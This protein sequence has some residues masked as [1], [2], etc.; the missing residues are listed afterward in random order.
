MAE[1]KS[2]VA[3]HQ[4]AASSTRFAHSKSRSSQPDLGFCPTTWRVGGV[5]LVSSPLSTRARGPEIVW[6]NEIHLEHELVQHHLC[7]RLLASATMS[8][9][10]TDWP[11]QPLPAPTQTCSNKLLVCARLKAPASAVST[12]AV[13]CAVFCKGCHCHA[14]RIPS[15][16]HWQARRLCSWRSRNRLRHDTFLLAQ[17]RPSL[18]FVQAYNGAFRNDGEE[19]TCTLTQPLSG[20]KSTPAAVAADDE[21]R[22]RAALPPLAM[23]SMLKSVPAGPTSTVCPKLHTVLA[24]DANCCRVTHRELAHRT[25]FVP[26]ALSVRRSPNIL[27]Q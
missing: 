9:T 13:E 22:P 8:V 6:F 7:A 23:P 11:I 3:A 26:N 10:S 21:H 1:A 16:L 24:L 12:H 15:F 17:Q 14:L 27:S 5:C 25:C 4:P 19:S 18:A 2:R 20:V